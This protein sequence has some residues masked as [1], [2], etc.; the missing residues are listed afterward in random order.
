MTFKNGSIIH[1]RHEPYGK[2][3]FLIVVSPCERGLTVEQFPRKKKNECRHSVYIDTHSIDSFTE[4]TAEYAKTVLLDRLEA[5]RKW[6]A[7]FEARI[8]NF[9]SILSSY[10]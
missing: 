4:V 5:E 7:D 2:E 1:S 8:K 10:V 3:H 9:D 6:L